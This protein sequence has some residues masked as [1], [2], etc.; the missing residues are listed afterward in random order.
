M[1]KSDVELVTEY[2]YFIL[3]VRTY[4]IGGTSDSEIREIRVDSMNELKRELSILGYY[5]EIES[6]EERVEYRVSGL[7]AEY[8]YD[9]D[10]DED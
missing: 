4:L 9:D 1:R 5:D 2:R 6:L 10:W 8:V 7:K 3:T